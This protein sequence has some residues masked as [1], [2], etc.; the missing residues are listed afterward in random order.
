MAFRG[1][2]IW[3]FEAE[4]SR[5]DTASIDTDDGYDED[6]DEPKTMSDGTDTLVYFTAVQVPCQVETERGRWQELQPMVS[7]QNPNT[8]IKLVFHFQDLEDL[9]LVDA[10]GRALIKKG[11]RLDAMYDPFGVEIDDYG[12]VPLY[13]IEATPR[14]AGLTGGSRNLLLCTFQERQ[15]SA[16]VT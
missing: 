9:G 8:E 16:I 2:L 14:S 3:P 10:N 7:G 1:R 15:R 13:C 6:F 5:L 4:I 12:S 11:D